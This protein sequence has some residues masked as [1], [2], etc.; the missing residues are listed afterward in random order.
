MTDRIL[1]PYNF[2]DS[3][4]KIIETNFQTHTD[5][6]KPIFSSIKN[7]IIDY[8]RKQQDNTCCYC[9]YQL[10]FDIKEVDIEHIVPKGGRKGEYE[11]FTFESSNLALSCPACN[12]KKSTKDVLNKKISS[13]PTDGKDFIIVHA[14]LDNYSEHI[15]IYNKCVFSAKTEKGKD[16]IIYCDLL[17]LSIV[18][19]KAKAYTPSVLKQLVKDLKNPNQQDKNELLAIIKN[20]IR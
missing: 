20:A 6:T 7:S 19:E 10:G 14:H 11:K 4:L 12:T 16:T 5:W 2:T 17:R 18:E 9:K 8:L 3:E 1:F 15:T 13:Y